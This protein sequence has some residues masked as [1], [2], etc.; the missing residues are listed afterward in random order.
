MSTEPKTDE[1]PAPSKASDVPSTPPA[2]DDTPTN[3]DNNGNNNTRKTRLRTLLSKAA[4]FGRVEVRGITP[5]PVKE[6]TVTRTVNVFTLW[7]SMNTNILGITFGLLAPVYGL[8]LRDASLVI[9]FF[10]LLTTILPAY[11]ATWGPRIG[12]RQMLQARYSFGRYLVSV[13][14]L[15]NLATLMGFCVIMAV[16]G[17]LCLSSVPEDAG[18]LSVTVG[19]VVIAVVTVG[20]SFCGFTVLHVYE[21]YAWIPATVALIVAVGTGGG[22]L[23]KQVVYDEVE[24][25]PPTAAAVL[26]F[27]MIVAS[28][29]VPW[30]CLSSD[31]TTYLRPDTSSTKI[32]TYTYLGLAL[33]TILLMT[34]GAAIG[35][36]IPNVPAWQAA[37][38]RTLVGGVLAAMLAPAGGFGKFLVVILSFSLLG[39]MAATS[40][41]IT[42]NLQLLLPWL[43]K[44]PRYLFS[45][46]FA[47]V[48]IP[49]AIKA[50]GEFFENLEN[51]V[52]LIGYWSSA[53]LAIVLVEHFVF[54]GGDCA[55][56]E[57]DA[58]NDAKRLPWGVA[59]LAAG[60]LSFG[61]V[62]PSMAQVWWTGPIAETTGDIGFELAFAVSGVLYVPLRWVERRWTGR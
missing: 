23:R 19:I 50:A 3:H 29:M 18:A 59:A 62:V 49:V 28:Y 6:R 12:M 54:R 51:F 56:Y 13:P 34:L 5:I 43:V 36:A 58:W 31:F 30:A 7:W 60:V 24:R 44:V 48:V 26:S 41:S 4:A 37:Y 42:L 14:V 46:V 57:F 2:A 9:L 33:P 35:N 45:I 10:T 17:G 11:L 47:A 38:D 15:L 52:A 40:Y 25:P 32:F 53:F 16:V 21:R 20:I 39:N 22:E 8:A 61:L 1:G 27:G 55:A